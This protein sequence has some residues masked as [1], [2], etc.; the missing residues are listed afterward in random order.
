MQGMKL[1]AALRASGIA[2][3]PLTWGKLWH[4]R[5]GVY[6]G[7]PFVRIKSVL[8]L[9]TD[10]PSLFKRNR[11]SVAAPTK[12]LY[13]DSREVTNQMTGHVGP[14]MILRYELFYLNC[15][16][17]LWWKRKRFD[18]IHVHTIEWPAFVAVRLGTRL[19]KPVVIKDSTMNGITN[20]LRYPKGTQKQQEIVAYG[21]FVAMTRVIHSNFLKAGVPPEHIVDIPNGIEITPLP[22]K[23]SA[24]KQRFIFVGNLRQ[25]PAKG[26][27]ILLLAWKELTA[28]FPEATLDI[29]GEGDLDAYQQ[30]AKNMGLSGSVHFLGKQHNIRQLL[31]QSDIFVL[32]SRREGMSNALMEA[33]ICGL[34]AIATE[35]SGSEDLIAQGISGLLVPVANVGALTAA[36]IQM[37]ED[38]E[39]SIEMG[40]RGYESVKEKCD[41]GEVTNRYIQ[42]YQ[43]ILHNRS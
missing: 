10:I 25:Q 1:A 19:N 32:P 34:P 28:H 36:M 11:R 23:A 38:P 35:V 41:I 8:N 31:T 13:D 18:I 39:R 24:W 12:I 14:A 7:I 40:R 20:V 21:Y 3:L 37:L 33:M 15:L 30:F 4:P 27:D 2:V 22:Q 29:V 6:N 16:L 26:I 43:Q 17:Y 5:R 9:I 42:L